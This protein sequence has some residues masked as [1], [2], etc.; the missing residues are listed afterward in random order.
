MRCIPGR[1]GDA[2]FCFFIFF[3]FA[4]EDAIRFRFEA[5]N[6]AADMLELALD[7]CSLV[8]ISTS[9]S[10]IIFILL[11]FPPTRAT[12]RFPLRRLI[13]PG[14][15]RPA[16]FKDEPTLPP[17]PSLF[18][19]APPPLAVAPLFSRAWAPPPLRRSAVFAGCG[20]NFVVVLNKLAP[21]FLFGIL[22]APDFVAPS[23]LEAL[24]LVGTSFAGRKL[25]RKVAFPP[26]TVLVG[27]LSLLLL[28]LLLLLTFVGTPVPCSFARWASS[29]KSI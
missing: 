8:K 26:F 13:P 24:L 5:R 14:R 3:W 28:L 11:D 2:I 6:S 20:L 27:L 10:S 25:G 29:C 19:T 17:P 7:C 4:K 9:S 23:V 1:D 18:N 22:R 15:G 21:G 16:A 12:S